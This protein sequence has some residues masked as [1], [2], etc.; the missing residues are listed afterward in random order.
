MLIPD[1]K[2][3]DL[4]GE[5][6]ILSQLLYDNHLNLV[7][8]Y[9][10]NCL[11]CTGRAI[12]HAYH[13]NNEYDFINLVVIHSSFGNQSFS[14]SDILSIFTRKSSPF[15]IYCESSH[16]LYDFF[17]CE[18]TPHWILLDGKENLIYSFFGSQ[19]NT[20]HKLYLAITEYKNKYIDQ[21]KE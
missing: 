6:H 2:L 5:N 11:G 21:E 4:N 18:G 9:N 19:E 20:K 15:P 17:Q 7:L 3:V 13:L 14:T 8:F 12:P 10:T 16:Q 1:V